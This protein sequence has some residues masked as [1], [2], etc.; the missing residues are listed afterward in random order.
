MIFNILTLFP[1][2]VQSF[3]RESIIGRAVERGILKIN[4]VNIRDYSTDKHGKVD[5]A[6]FGGGR[7]MLL[8]PD[9]LFRSLDSIERRGTVIYLNPMGKRL[10][11]RGVRDLSKLEV[12]TL[13]CGHY[14]GIDHRVVE[15][16]V[17]EEVSIGD[18]ILTGGEPAA[19]V[20]VDSVTREL[21]GALGTDESRIEESFDLTGLLEYEQYTRP[22]SYRGIKVPE[23][24]LSGNHEE[25]R[26]WRM[27]RRLE[28]TIER[29]M[30]L[31]SE[32]LESS[33]L[34]DEYIELLQEIEK[35]KDNEDR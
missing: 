13:I 28:N 8:T 4:V 35:E 27:K 5:D 6:P 7:G 10:D 22:A 17:D 12:V 25:I 26:K 24:L 34:A 20:L 15:A 29:R 32:G 1:D 18:Y 19:C 3:F 9:P 31:L 23:V 11:Q 21:E 16:L 2:M 33:A 14:E 30:D